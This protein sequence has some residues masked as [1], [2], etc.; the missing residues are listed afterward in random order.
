MVVDFIQQTIGEKKIKTLKTFDFI[1]IENVFNNIVFYEKMFIDNGSIAFRNAN[2]SHEEHLNFHNVF[3]KQLG[4]YREKNKTGYTENHSRAHD[5]KLNY[6]KNEIMLP[7][8]IE[9]PHYQNP[10]VLGTWNMHKFTTDSENGKTYFVDNQFLYQKMSDSFK[11]FSKKCIILNPV[12]KQQGISEEHKLIE[13]H[14]ITKEPVIRVSHVFKTLDSKKQTAKLNNFQKL[15]KFEGRDP[16]KN[17]YEYYF[18]IMKWI[19]DQLY[20]NLDNR[21]VHKWQQGDLVVSDMYKM[22]HAVTGGFESKDR[23]FIG[24]WGRRN[25]NENDTI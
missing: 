9:H 13:T 23:E 11:E 18:E 22:C 7:W 20:N 4:S 17:E 2:L 19:E 12:G 14:W 6:G 24:I 21:I 8:H 16:V 1:S 15:Y 10:I 3:G 5:K 25:K